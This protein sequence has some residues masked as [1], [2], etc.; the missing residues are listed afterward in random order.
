MVSDAIE[1]VGACAWYG[2]H[3]G[4]KVVRAKR[5]SVS[6]FQYKAREC[7]FIECCALFETI[8]RERHKRGVYILS[9]IG[10]ALRIE[11]PFL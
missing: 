3:V 1:F 9:G 7:K 2:R 10:C 8:S 4:A 6:C 5:R 11:S